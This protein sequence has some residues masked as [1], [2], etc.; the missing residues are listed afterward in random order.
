MIFRSIKSIKEAGLKQSNLRER[1]LAGILSPELVRSGRRLSAFLKENLGVVGVQDIKGVE[2]FIKARKFKGTTGDKLNLNIVL[3]KAVV[4]VVFLG[5]EGAKSGPSFDRIETFRKLGAVVAEEGAKAKASK[6]TLISGEL[7]ISSFDSSAAFVEGAILSTYSFNKYKKAAES[8]SVEAIEFVG[9]ALSAEGC[10]FGEVG[11][12]STM[13]ARDLVNLSP[14]DCPPSKIVA[15]ARAVAREQKLRITVFDKKR[16]QKMGSNLHLAV[17]AGSDEPPYLVKLEYRPRKARKTI[18]IV[19]KGVTFDSGGLSIKPASG[20]ETMKCDM[21]GAAAALGAIEA[22]ARLKLNVAVRA[23]LPL[24][25][26]MINGK[27]TRPGDVIKSRA[28]KT[29]EILNTDAEGRLILADALSVA[30]EDK[31]DYIVDVATLTGACVVALGGDIAG[32]FSTDDKLA[33][34]I[35][36][37]ASRAG[38]RVW[39]MPLPA[40]YLELTKSSIAD[41]KNT[42]G[43]EGGAITAALFLKEFVDKTPWAHIDIAGPAFTSAKWGYIKKGGVGFGV[44]TLLRLVHD[45]A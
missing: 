5:W 14:I 15:E 17:S 32:L 18:A 44:R 3:G 41:L 23:Y 26:N 34:Q 42:G 27:A 38:E 24:T 8:V 4:P 10:S 29:V 7:E 39:R 21:S 22:A 16:L 6:I 2:A 45:L 11:A 35:A 13:R 20:M 1:L 28:G 33:E 30:V 40:H 37:S 31:C 19:G 36:D 43:R 9:A 12:L 25:E